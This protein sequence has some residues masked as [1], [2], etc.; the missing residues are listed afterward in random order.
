[1]KKIQLLVLA[2]FAVSAFSAVF[3]GSALAEITL[4][5]EWLVGTT[6]VAITEN[7]ASETSGEI[8][9]EDTKAGPFGEPAAVLCSGILDGTVG[10][11][12]TDLIEK[13]LNLKGEE[14]GTPLVGLAL[15]GEGAGTDCIAISTCQE[16]TA[17]SPIEV[18]PENLSWATELFLMEDGKILDLVV[19]AAY[20]ILCL[21]VLGSDEVDLCESL[22]AEFEVLNDPE[23]GDAEIPAKASGL[24]FGNCIL[25]GTGTGNNETDA[26]TFITLVN[27]ELLT[28]SSV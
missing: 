19:N 24:P 5:A 28:V 27:R 23:T 4:L 13:V 1:M 20:E 12:G 14:I 8:R 21:S 10:P 26:L 25:G 7:L 15:L 9:L 3:A 18:W 17:A 2:V 16:G 11:N 22:D 6:G